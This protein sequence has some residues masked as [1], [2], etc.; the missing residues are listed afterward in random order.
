MRHLIALTLIMLGGCTLTLGPAPPVEDMLLQRLL[1][2]EML[3]DEYVHDDMLHAE[4]LEAIEVTTA[5]T[6]PQTPA[7]GAGGRRPVCRWVCR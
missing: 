1:D 7:P 5:Q 3:R 4:E 6:P 2:S